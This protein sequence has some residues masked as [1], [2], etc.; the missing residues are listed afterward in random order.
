L[1]LHNHDQAHANIATRRSVAAIEYGECM[2]LTNMQ[3]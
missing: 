3:V 2:E 1:Q